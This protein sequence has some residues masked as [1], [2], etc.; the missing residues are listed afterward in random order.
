M[1]KVGWTCDAVDG[2]N[3]TAIFQRHGFGNA[4]AI[5][6]SRDFAF[7]VDAIQRRFQHILRRHQ[8]AS[9][10]QSPCKRRHRTV[11]LFGQRGYL[12]ALQFHK[13]YD[14]PVGF[15]GGARH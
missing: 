8:Q 13:L 9:A 7:Q 3:D 14:Q 11:P 2:V 10:I 12:A 5:G 4:T 15:V 1:H 6:Q